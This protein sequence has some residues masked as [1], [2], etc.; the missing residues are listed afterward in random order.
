M[1][2]WPMRMLGWITNVMAEGFASARKI[3]TVFKYETK[4]KNKENGF[5]TDAIEG[6][7]EFDHVSLKLNDTEILKDL[8]FTIEPNKTL[9]I[10]GATGSGKS[11]IINLLTRFYDYTAGQIKIDDRQL[12][13]YDLSNLRSHIS[14]VMQDVFLFS[15]TIEENILFGVKDT[16]DHDAMVENSMAAQAH[17]FIDR[18]DENYQTVIGEKGIGLSGGQ[19]QRIS[20]ARAL[21]KNSGILVFDDSTSALDMETEYRIQEEIDKLD[22]VTKIIIAHRISAVKKADE[23]IIL[24]G[25]AIVE[26]GSHKELLAQKGPY[27]ETYK[28]QYEGFMAS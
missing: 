10:M 25:G 2:I 7:I 24:E 20:I 11:S 22:H 28:E 5:K 12:A 16:T 18:M 9:A 15:D 19:K 26:R 1:V 4:I 23:I 8:S 3:D 27:Y 13:D 21:A 14:V 6:K 17:D